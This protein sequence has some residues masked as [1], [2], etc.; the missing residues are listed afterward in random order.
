MYNMVQCSSYVLHCSYKFSARPR[1]VTWDSTFVFRDLKLLILEL[2][3][4]FHDPCALLPLTPPRLLLST[5]CLDVATTL[6]LFSSIP[7]PKL[8]F[9]GLSAEPE[10]IRSLYGNLKAL[11]ECLS[12]APISMD[13]L[14]FLVSEF[15]RDSQRKD[16]HERTVFKLP[17]AVASEIFALCRH[18]LNKMMEVGVQLMLIRIQNKSAGMQQTAEETMI[19]FN[20]T[21]DLFL[22]TTSAHVS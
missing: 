9:A 15:T 3:F 14:K 2:P 10:P 5:D 7:S 6:L 8:L 4:F 20:K 18:L 12:T 21:A 22:Y 17:A 1:S 19:Y 16:L 13:H 11:N